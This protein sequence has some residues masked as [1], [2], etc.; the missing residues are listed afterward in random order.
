M[1]RIAEK[2]RAAAARA[3]EVRETRAAV[4]RRIASGELDL[5]ALLRGDSS[6]EADLI[7]GSDEAVAE[8]IQI[9]HLLRS[10]PGVGPVIAQEILDDCE[11]GADRLLADLDQAARELLAEET[12]AITREGRR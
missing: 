10:V 1:S 11:L 4:K 9:G 2:R 3:T 7:E 5:A 6:L 8:E 12:E